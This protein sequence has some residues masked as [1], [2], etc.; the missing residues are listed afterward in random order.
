M[1]NPKKCFAAA[2]HSFDDF[3]KKMPSDHQVIFGLK[4][5]ENT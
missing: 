5:L 4:V 1:G 2:R 3:L